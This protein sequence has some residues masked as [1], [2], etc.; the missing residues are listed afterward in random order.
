MANS[1][2]FLSI[3]QCFIGETN[4]TASW[5]IFL[6]CSASVQPAVWPAACCHWLYFLADKTIPMTNHM[7]GQESLE[8]P[9]WPTKML[10]CVLVGFGNCDETCLCYYLRSIISVVSLWKVWEPVFC[11][12]TLTCD[13]DMKSTSKS[14][15]IKPWALTP[16]AKSNKNC[17]HER[18]WTL[19][20]A[21]KDHGTSA[22]LFLARWQAGDR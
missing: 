13:L 7:S 6:L 14:S 3:Y 19:Q 10:L 2:S 17:G 16:F 4:V 18:K 20:A 1:F 15:L 22:F 8:S 9:D 12:A 21:D 5:V 11:F